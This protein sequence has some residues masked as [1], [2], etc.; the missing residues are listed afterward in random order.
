VRERFRN[1][2]E[3]NPNSLS[4]PQK[5]E[6]LDRVDRRNDFEYIRSHCILRIGKAPIPTGLN[7]RVV[8]ST[9]L[10]ALL[11]AM[12]KLAGIMREAVVGHA[13]G[14]AAAL[15]AYYA[16]FELPEG[17]NTIVAGPR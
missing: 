14:A 9:A 5:F 7:S 4:D 15:D 2:K 13:F 17:L 11:L 16:A 3:E 1:T 8:H 12:D 10:V 6:P